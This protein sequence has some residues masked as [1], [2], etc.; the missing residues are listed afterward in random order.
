M[1]HW[2]NEYI[3]PTKSKGMNAEISY[4]IARDFMIE[5]AQPFTLDISKLK[6]LH[7]TNKEKEV[8][9]NKDGEKETPVIAPNPLLL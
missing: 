9:E 5:M 8:Q 2:I 1:P 6:K 3:D 4:D 7:P